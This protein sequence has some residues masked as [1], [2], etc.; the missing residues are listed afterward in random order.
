MHIEAYLFFDGRCEEAVEFYKKALGAEVTMLMRF[1]DSPE[2]PTSPAWS[3]PGFSENKIMHVEL[4][5]WR[6]HG[7][8]VRRA[9]HGANRLPRFF[10]LAHGGKRRRGLS[11]NL[12]R[13]AEEG[14]SGADAASRRHFWSPRFGMVADRFG[15][16]WMVTVMP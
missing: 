2:P 5:D 11:G 13:L 10:P 1:K 9:L 6:F 3:R 8:G 14:G 15:V 7:D 4:S 16:G 12:P